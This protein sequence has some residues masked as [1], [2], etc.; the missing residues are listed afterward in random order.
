MIN[1]PKI[2]LPYLHYKQ[3]INYKKNVLHLLW[4]I[5]KKDPTFSFRPDG[6]EKQSLIKKYNE[7]ELKD[8]Q[9]NEDFH[10]CIAKLEHLNKDFEFVS[11]DINEKIFLSLLQI[12]DSEV[13]YTQEEKNILNSREPKVASLVT[14]NHYIYLTFLFDNL[15]KF[16]KINILEFGGGFGNI[17]R[18]LFKYFEEQKINKYCI[19]DQTGMQQLQKYFLKENLKKDDFDKISY[20]V[21]DDKIKIN[22][23]YDLLIANHSLSEFA[24]TKYFEYSDIIK[25]VKYFFYSS[26]LTTICEFVKIFHIMSEMETVNLVFEPGLNVCHFL[27]K[28]KENE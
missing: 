17:C 22:E 24:I 23:N 16:K 9:S 3:D 11:K 18:M 5:R 8:F 10:F 1:E 13:G 25:K 14:S 6:W 4:E 19:A 15:P 21:S 27:F 20:I 28:R 7:E 12:G 2:I 26:T